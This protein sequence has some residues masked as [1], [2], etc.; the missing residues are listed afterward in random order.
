M[1]G[2]AFGSCAQIFV[3]VGADK[4]GVR[5]VL[6]QAVDFPLSR[7]EAGCGWLVE[8]LH[9]GVFGVEIQVD[10]RAK[11][12]IPNEPLTPSILIKNIF[13]AASA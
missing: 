11:G 9:D 1:L 10:L 7:Q 12:N 2:F 6:H 3:E 5:V 13:S 4:P 8:A